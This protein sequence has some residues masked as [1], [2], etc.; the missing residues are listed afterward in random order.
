MDVYRRYRKGIVAALGALLIIVPEL[1]PVAE[2]IVAVLT[3][4]G[5]VAVPND[6]A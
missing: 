2:E 5:V 6:P 4:A 1:R 3:L